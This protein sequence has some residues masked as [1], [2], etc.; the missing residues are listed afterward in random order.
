MANTT[1]QAEKVIL[2]VTNHIFSDETGADVQASMERY[3]DILETQVEQQLGDRIVELEV[4]T[5]IGEANHWCE[6]FA[7]PE[8][9]PADEEQLRDELTYIGERVLDGTYGDW[10]VAA[11]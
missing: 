1:A 7:S 3:A 2:T 8:M 5:Q 4:H 6:V 10:V 11:R 9:K